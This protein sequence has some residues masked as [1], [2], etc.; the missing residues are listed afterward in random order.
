M[1]VHVHID[2]PRMQVNET[3]TG[4]N[5]EAVVAAMK[6]RVARDM[7]FAMRMMVNA[8]SPLRFAQEAVKKY[9][10]NMKTS[11]ALPSTCEEFLQLAEQHGLATIDPQ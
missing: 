10:E 1:K 4:D 6:A 7:P 8:M 5:A 9:N 3:F 2:H 11:I